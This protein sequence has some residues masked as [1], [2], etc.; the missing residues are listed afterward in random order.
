MS[1]TANIRGAHHIHLTVLDL[2]E[3]YRRVINR[4]SRLEQL[5]EMRAPGIIVRNEKRMLKAA[6]DDLFDGTEV[7]AMHSRIG[8]GIVTNSFNFISGTEIESPAVNTA[9]DSLGA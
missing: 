6:M 8:A 3:K 9:S 2:E 7:E 1:D 4:R 5:V